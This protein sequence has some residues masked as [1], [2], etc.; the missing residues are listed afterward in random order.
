MWQTAHGLK[1][2][3]VHFRA[4]SVFKAAE[5]LVKMGREKN[6]NGIDAAYDTLKREIE[7]LEPALAALTEE[8]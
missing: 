7:S 1:G 3:V 4:D 8:C 6:M 2:S 5:R